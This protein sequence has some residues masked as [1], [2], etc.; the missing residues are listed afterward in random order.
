MLL[1]YVPGKLASKVHLL[2]SLCGADRA[3]FMALTWIKNHNA[4]ERLL[5]STARRFRREDNNVSLMRVQ[6]YKGSNYANSLRACVRK[7]TRFWS[8]RVAEQS[9]CVDD[10]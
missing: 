8:I 10:M 5:L 9:S 7:D 4:K 6:P 2:V 3:T 1:S